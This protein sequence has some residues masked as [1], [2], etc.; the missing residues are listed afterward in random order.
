[1]VWL[2]R[3]WW[4]RWLAWDSKACGGTKTSP[5]EQTLFYL[6]LNDE[7][8]VMG[9]GDEF[10]LDTLY[11]L[12]RLKKCNTGISL[13]RRDSAEVVGCSRCNI[14]RPLQNM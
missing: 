9:L 10:Y 14:G 6:A 8:V 7:L 2:D 3:A 13:A 5:Q 12:A 11:L 1:M 4:Q